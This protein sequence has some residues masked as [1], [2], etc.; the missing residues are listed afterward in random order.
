M[1]QALP[2]LVALGIV[3]LFLVVL[4]VAPP[5]A[6]GARVGTLPLGTGSFALA[7]VGTYHAPCDGG[8]LPI[9]WAAFVWQSNRS[10]VTFHLTGA[11][12]ATRPTHV[13]FGFSM[14]LTSIEVLRD[15][16]RFAHCPPLHVPPAPPTT[17]PVPP[18]LP[19]SGRT[20]YNI[21][22]LPDATLFLL[23]IR[24]FDSADVITVTEPF[25]V[26]AV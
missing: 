17:P 22:T 18:S 8:T 6:P 19:T 2:A 21:T 12:T 13:E 25:T 1:R 26:T 11:W 23:V 9:R 15:W 24:T 20:D 5:F 10:N 4:I 3:G 14:N 7:M 16:V